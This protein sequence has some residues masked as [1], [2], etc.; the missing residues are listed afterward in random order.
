MTYIIN[1]WEKYNQLTI[2]K[3]L[4]KKWKQRYVQCKCDCWI[5]KNYYMNNIKSWTTKSCGCFNI[6]RAIETNTT[7]WLT[8]HRLFRIW[9]WMK[10]RCNNPKTYWYK[11]YGW[12]WIKYCHT[13]KSFIIFYKDMIKLYNEHIILHWEKNTTLDRRK[14]DWWYSKENCHWATWEEQWKNKRRTK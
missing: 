7:H 8:N 5:V 14:N 4:D 12:R 11:W 9:N 6:K 3:E 2:L 1:V 10:E 13:W